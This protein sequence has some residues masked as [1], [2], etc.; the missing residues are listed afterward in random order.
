M[1]LNSTSLDSSVQYVGKNNI[2]VGNKVSLPITRIG[3]SHSLLDVLL[4]PCLTKNLLLISKLTSYFHL[5][6]IFIFSSFIV[7]NRV[8]RKTVTTKK[9]DDGLYI[10]KHD[11]ASYLYF[12][13]Q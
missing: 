4:V 7:Q 2:G 9:N 8:S 5:Q 10:L 11:N 6:V 3:T 1:T 12:C 13:P